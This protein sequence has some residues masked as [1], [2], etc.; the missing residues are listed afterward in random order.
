[1]G[2]VVSVP[3]LSRAFAERRE[4]GERV[5]MTNG[6][7]DL[8]HAGHVRYLSRA[9]AR[10]DCLAVAANSDASVRRL[11]GPGRPLNPLSDRLC[12]LAALAS[13]DWVVA[14]DE[15]TPDALYRELLPDLLVK[16][17]DW[18]PEQVAGGDW[19]RSA[20]GEVLALDYLPGRSTSGLIARIQAAA[21]DSGAGP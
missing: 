4:R 14:F 16:G 7:F 3:E 1:M 17:G 11:K 13:V 9:R 18:R 2:V 10:G 12:V 8:L 6:C 19:V 20:G 15:D 21:T 5:V